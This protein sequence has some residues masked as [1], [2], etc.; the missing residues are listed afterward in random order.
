MGVGADTG[1]TD[2]SNAKTGSEGRETAAETTSEVLV[3][4][5]GSVLGVNITGAG[6]SGSCAIRQGLLD[7]S[8]VD[9]SNNK[10]VN[11]E[12]TSHN[13]G[14]QTLEHEVLSEDTDG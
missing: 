8:L 10:A 4:F 13:A 3:A 12:D 14:N 6:S 2:N 1:I 5:V 9:N 7:L 11:T